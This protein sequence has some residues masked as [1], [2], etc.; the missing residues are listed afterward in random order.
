M[1]TGLIAL[2]SLRLGLF[3]SCR[4]YL[5]HNIYH[6][7][8][9]LTPTSANPGEEFQLQNLPLPTTSPTPSRLFSRDTKEKLHSSVSRTVF[10]TCFSESCML[11]LLLM[12]QG[13]AVFS[14]RERLLNW[15]FSIFVLLAN[16]AVLIP[17]NITLLLTMGSDYKPGDPKRRQRLMP[18]LF[19]SLFFVLL[20]LYALSYVPLPAGL[21]STDMFTTLLSRLIVIGTVILGLLS[22]FGAIS[23]PWEFFRSRTQS[24]VPTDNDIRVAE[25][26]LTRIREDLQQRRIASQ[27]RTQSP[28]DYSWY[29][30]FVPNMRGNDNAQEIQGLEALEYQMDRNLREMKGRR[31]NAYFYRT[32][33]GRLY[34]LGFTLFSLY[35]LLRVFLTSINVLL[36]SFL[37]SEDKG[38]HYSDLI[39][40]LLG[41]VVPTESTE[42]PLYDVALLA[43]Q[44]SLALV[45]V[46]IF[47]SIR[48][49]LQAVTRFLRVT[50]RNLGASLMLLVLAQLMG[51]YLLS[52]IVQ[53]RNTF[54]PPEIIPESPDLATTANL[55]STIPEFEVFGSLFNWTFLLAAAATV[56]IRWAAEKVD[57]SKDS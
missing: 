49:V 20:Y 46:M 43:R 14:P 53:L 48:A 3:F 37:S 30:R 1:L 28:V 51:I 36:P 26:S 9:D 41:H 38:T 47:S 2:V 40:E 54:P 23:N 7:L 25:S 21:V 17:A 42:T 15:K 19:L 18:K 12:M 39:A 10:S 11:F 31:D 44:I 8:R 34:S 32:L 33:K 57:G 50:S 4:K 56:F 27:A 45:G 24:G 52:T 5:L 13:L 6:G 16:I 55:F 29:S 22:G 35:C